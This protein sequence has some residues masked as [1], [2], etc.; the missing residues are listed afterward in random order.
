MLQDNVL[1]GSSAIIEKCKPDYERQ[2]LLAKERHNKNKDFQDA[3]FN[4]MGNVRLRDKMAE[5]MG[6]LVSESRQLET[7]IGQ[8]IKEQEE[9]K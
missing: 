3:I 6:E 4:Y 9:Q 2:I 5:L 8:M 1:E 7:S